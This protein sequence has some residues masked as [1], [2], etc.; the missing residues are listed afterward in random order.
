MKRTVKVLALASALLLL[1]SA[2]LVAGGQ[3]EEG[4]KAEKAK[5]VVKYSDS[6]P[7]GGVRTAFLADFFLPEI[8]K[9]TDGQVEFQDFW[10]GAL[11]G[12][13]EALKGIKDGITDIGFLFPEFFPEQLPLHQ[14]FKL[15]P[16]G[17][18]SWEAQRWIYETAYEEI[19]ELEEELVAKWNQK[20]LLMTAGLPGTFTSSYKVDSI[21]DLDGKKWRASSRWLLGYL[22]SAGAIPVSV[23]WADC[24]MALQTGTVDGVLANLDGIHMT[25]QDEAAGYIFV[26]KEMWWA[27]PFLHTVNLDFWN[28]LPE[29]VQNDMLKAAE[30]AKDAYAEAYDGAFDEITST[31]EANGI[32]VEIASQEEIAKWQ[33]ISQAEKYQQQFVAEL[34]KNGYDNA[35]EI[36]DKMRS[37]VKRGLEMD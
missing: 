16:V 19:P 8:V 27:T 22:K 26:A 3:S 29:D 11:L 30:N 24:Y 7:P 14:I 35:Q 34:K 10:G 36:M 23:P 9:Q 37:I 18:G 15:F 5:I 32:E 12:P 28:S 20:P 2:V 33:K 1:V 17:P 6:D 31:Q 13:P 21:D 25:K 4:G